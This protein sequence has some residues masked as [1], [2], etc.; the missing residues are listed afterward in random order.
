MWRSFGLVLLTLGVVPVASAIEEPPFKSLL[1]E[2]DYEVRQ[3]AP[4]VVAEVV[5]GG[6]LETASS[7]G[8]SLVAGY[9]CGGN[10]TVSAVSAEPVSERIAMTAPVVAVPEDRQSLEG[11]NRWRVQFVMPS[12]SIDKVR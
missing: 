4:T 11:A 2:G 7:R 1:K 9:I 5:V 10:R 12:T 3:Y 8:F 6:D